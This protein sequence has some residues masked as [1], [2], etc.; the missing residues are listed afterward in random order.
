MTLALRDKIKY[1]FDSTEL[2]LREKFVESH[3]M[4]LKENG[5]NIDNPEDLLLYIACL[6]GVSKH[7]NGDDFT[8]DLFVLATR[9]YSDIKEKFI[10]TKEEE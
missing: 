8:V 4:V 3:R 1:V 7:E 5:I 6:F 9:Y 10:S 2:D